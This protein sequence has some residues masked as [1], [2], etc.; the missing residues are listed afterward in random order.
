MFSEML[1]Q[2]SFADTAHRVGLVKEEDVTR[3]LQRSASGATLDASDLIAL[4]SPAARESLEAM[5]RLAQETTRRRFGNIIQIYAP[6][7]LSNE[8]RSSCTYC[9]FSYENDIRRHTLTIAETE[10]EADLLYTQGIR[11]VLLL[12]GEDYKNT[13]VRY[14]SEVCRKLSNRFSSISIEVYPLKEEDYKNLRDDGVDGLAVYQETYDPEV[15][16]RVH[17][18]GVKKNMEFR[19]D[20]PDRAGRAGIRKIALGALLGLADPVGEVFALAAHARYVMHQYWQSQ[21]SISL[22][23]LRPAEG[24][25]VVP[26]IPDRTYVQYLLALRLYLPDAGLIL[27]TREPAEFRD[28]L[29]RICITQMSAGSKTEPGGYSGLPTDVQFEIEDTRSVDEFC[30][31]LRSNGLEPVFTDW[32]AI[33]K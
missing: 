17:L 32:N 27:S 3:A 18:R 30:R 23:R 7:Y 33:L 24:L 6:M 21:V 29:S 25:T 10:R 11:H 15:Y 1:K 28:H 31:A 2:F 5:A 22:P 4:I 26:V 9:G 20:C 8:C 14:L 12:T 19:L 16:A 13:P